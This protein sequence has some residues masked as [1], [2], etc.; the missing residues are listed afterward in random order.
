MTASQMTTHLRV[1]RSR[2]DG[3]GAPTVSADTAGWQ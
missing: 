3:S 1:S 2:T